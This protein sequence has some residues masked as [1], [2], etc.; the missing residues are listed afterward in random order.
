MKIAHLQNLKRPVLLCELPEGANDTRVAKL[1]YEDVVAFR[2]KG[3]DRDEV[4]ILPPGDWDGLG[5]LTELK[6]ELFAE[7]AADRMT[8]RSTNNQIWYFNYRMTVGAPYLLLAKDSFLSCVESHGWTWENPYG[9]KP[10]HL[11]DKWTADNGFCFGSFQK[12]L[13]L[14]QSAQKKVL[15]RERCFVIVKNDS[16]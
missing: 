16:K 10:D 7:L 4:I 1:F 2:P 14:W 8:Y 5:W 9:E 13:R 3:S 15:D 6:E 12:S 11:S